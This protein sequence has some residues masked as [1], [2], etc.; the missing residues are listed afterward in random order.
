MENYIEFILTLLGC[1]HTPTVISEPAEGDEKVLAKMYF[2]EYGLGYLYYNTQI[3]D[4]VNT[5]MSVTHELRHYYQHE[6]IELRS[7]EDKETINKWEYDF[8]HYNGAN[9]EGY[10]EQEVEL[11]ANAFAVFIMVAVFNIKM[12]LTVDM[13]RLTKF[14]Q[15]F[16]KEDINE[17]VEELE[18]N[19][20]IIPTIN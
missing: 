8:A 17:L 15:E 9:E 6:Q 11:D 20:H 16:T 3:A 19:T 10:S 4:N 13:F 14:A 5:Y 1:I 12:D 2:D 7:I 18:L